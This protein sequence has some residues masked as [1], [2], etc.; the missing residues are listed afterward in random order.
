MDVS[1][2][3]DKDV[4]ATNNLLQGVRLTVKK[5]KITKKYDSISHLLTMD[6]LELAGTKTKELILLL[7]DTSDHK[8]ILIESLKSLNS[9]NRSL[10]KNNLALVIIETIQSYRQEL[11]DLFYEYDDAYPILLGESNCLKAGQRYEGEI[12]MAA[13]KLTTERIFEADYPDDDQGFIKLPI[14]N[15]LGGKIVI[16]KLKPG[17]TEIKIRVIESQLNQK[18]RFENTVLLE[19]Q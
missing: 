8:H 6:D 10:F 5:D 1:E 12:Q 13:M 11:D 2:K 16:D 15:S 3:L 18:L 4:E 19:S 14:T 9:S 17:R 7:N